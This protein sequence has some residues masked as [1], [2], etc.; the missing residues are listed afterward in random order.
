VQAWHDGQDEDPQQWPS[1]Q[2]PPEHSWPDPQLVPKDLSGAHELPLQP[3]AQFTLGCAGH[4][5]LLQ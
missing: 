3:L 2:L 5:P 4:V 1:T